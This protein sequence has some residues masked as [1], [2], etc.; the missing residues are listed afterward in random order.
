VGVDT[1][2]A[3]CS[4]STIVTKNSR[5]D[6]VSEIPTILDLNDAC[7][8]LHNTIKDVTK[9]PEFQWMLSRLRPTLKHFSKSSHS[10]AHLRQERR[11]DNDDQTVRA[12]Q[13]IGNTRF[14]THW[15]AATSLEQCLPNIRGLVEKK[16]IKFKVSLSCL[17]VCLN[18][19]Q[20]L[21][22]FLNR[23]PFTQMG[24]DLNIYIEV[25]G[26]FIRSLW[27][28]EAAHANAS[29][30]FIF[31]LA[32]GASLKDLISK[33]EEMTGIPKTLLQHVI[34]IYNN[35]WRDFFRNDVYFMA[36]ALDPRMSWFQPHQPGNMSLLPLITSLQAIQC[37]TSF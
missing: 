13:K 16:T 18:M 21:D 4:D 17:N 32:I 9:L 35:W 1:W 2:A 7:H 29:D 15:M 25:V 14:G 6:I 36:F 34:S 19:C 37:P 28:L 8:H 30:V 11:V 3:I 27:S 20:I 23:C 22:M 5:H 12:L 31:W 26:P 33:D 10:V 24:R